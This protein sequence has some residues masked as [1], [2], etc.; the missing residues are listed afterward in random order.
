LTV[1]EHPQHNVAK[2]I[3]LP[4]QRKRRPQ[5]NDASG[6]FELGQNQGGSR[7]QVMR[8]LD[9]IERGPVWWAL[10]ETRDLPECTSHLI[11]LA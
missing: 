10:T 9:A 5:A 6:T 11:H 2:R 8:L 7:F 4:E 3:S 1:P